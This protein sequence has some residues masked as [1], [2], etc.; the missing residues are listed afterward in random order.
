[1]KNKLHIAGQA[2]LIILVI[3]AV[4]WSVAQIPGITPDKV[5]DRRSLENEGEAA[6][7]AGTGSCP[8]DKFQS[9][10]AVA[11]NSG[12]WQ[13][14]CKKAQQQTV[15]AQAHTKQSQEHAKRAQE[16]VIEL[17]ELLKGHN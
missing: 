17:I 11:W 2:I 14:A 16:Q 6:Y 7:L 15:T 8:Y 10:E 4:T 5:P 13:A 9:Y 1:M 3:C 12:W